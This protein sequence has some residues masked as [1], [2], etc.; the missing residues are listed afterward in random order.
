[1]RYALACLALLALAGC[2]PH[3]LK[4]EFT[5]PAELDTR[6]RAFQAHVIPDGCVRGPLRPRETATY[7]FARGEAPPVAIRSLPPGTWGFELEALDAYCRP[8]GRE[9]VQV[10]L[11]G[12][13]VLVPIAP[14]DAAE[15]S[16]CE[17]ECTNGLCVAPQADPSPTDSG[18]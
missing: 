14:L 8:V 6:V 9:C 1:M 7:R 5:V 13:D 11:P 16:V 2:R 3:E 15:P 4:W 10:E 12:A 18:V 17:G